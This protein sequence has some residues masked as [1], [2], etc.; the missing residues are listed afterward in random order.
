MTSGCVEPVAYTFTVLADAL[1]RSLKLTDPSGKVLGKQIKQD[2]GSVA[3]T[4]EKDGRYEYCFSNQ[5]SAIADK[6]VRYVL[7]L[8]RLPQ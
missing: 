1:Q 3:I 2:T 6:M 4:A 8:P 7:M 5:M